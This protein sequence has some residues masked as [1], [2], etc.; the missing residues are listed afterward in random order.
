MMTLESPLQPDAQERVQPQEP[1]GELT[2]ELLDGFALD[3]DDF[4]RL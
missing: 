2:S 1:C 4:F 3:L